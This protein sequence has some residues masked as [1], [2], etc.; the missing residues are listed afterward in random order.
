[1]QSVQFENKP[2]DTGERSNPYWCLQFGTNLLKIAKLFPL[3]TAVM[4]ARVASSAC[5]EEY[6]RELKQLV[7]KGAKY[8]R[9]DKFLVTHIRS[10]AGAVK[11]LQASNL[12]V[13]SNNSN[14]SDDD[15]DLD[16]SNIP[17]FS[18]TPNT[19]INNNDSSINDPID[20]STDFKIANNENEIKYTDISAPIDNNAID[21]DSNIEDT[22][23]NLI[24]STYLNK[25]EKWRGKNNKEPRKIFN[26]MSGC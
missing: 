10:F 20:S 18:I 12:H 17:S 4:S 24:S 2:S 19:T 1:M 23:A 14:D 5:S 11:I 6:F 13:A 15:I 22:S 16:K 3:W 26:C 7:F 8:T 9:V 21:S 25:V